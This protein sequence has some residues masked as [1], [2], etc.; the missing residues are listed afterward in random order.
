MNINM[1]QNKKNNVNDDEQT[2][3]SCW[4]WNIDSDINY[5]RFCDIW[6]LLDLSH[7]WYCRYLT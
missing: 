5:H 4:N 7:R 3:L 1:R 6:C 2:K